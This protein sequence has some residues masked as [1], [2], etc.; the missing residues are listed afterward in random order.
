MF[1][2]KT[3]VKV[4]RVSEFGERPFRSF[5]VLARKIGVLRLSDGSFKAMEARCKHQG[6]DLA[7]G[8]MNGTKVTCSRH[9]WIYDLMTGE[10]TNTDSLP[11]R[12]H[13]LKIEDDWV[14]VA[15]APD[16]AAPQLDFEFFKIT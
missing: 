3:Y 5:D 2:D 15:A 1:D 4:V 13:A 9:G 12:P 6:A 14:L 8:P 7:G 10:C 16:E 11:L